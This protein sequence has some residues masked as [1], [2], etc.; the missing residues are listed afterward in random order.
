[1]HPGSVIQQLSLWLIIPCNRYQARKKQNPYRVLHPNI[2]HGHYTPG[3]DPKQMT[4]DSR[5][6]KEN[7][8]FTIRPFRETDVA[9]VT[10]GQ[11]ALYAAEYGFTSHVWHN[12]LTGGVQDF[13]RQFDPARDCMYIAER[14]GAPCGCIAI[15]HTDN[16]TAQL[17]FYFVEKECRGMGAGRRLIDR[18]IG[19]CRDAQYQR[20]F[21]WTFSTLDA[22]RHLY[23]GGGFSITD[24]HLNSEWGEPILEEKWELDL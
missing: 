17:R 8:A 15:T 7:P 19:F 16:G 21:L 23:A 20:V 4:E 22:A 11:L 14:D 9:Y 10:A 12:Y 6:L 1:L 2:F 13:V 3:K 18:A 24:T 5:T